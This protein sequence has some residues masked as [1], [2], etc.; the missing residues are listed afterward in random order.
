LK[1]PSLGGEGYRVRFLKNVTA[2]SLKREVLLPFKMQE[3]EEK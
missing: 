1:S 2:L 3:R